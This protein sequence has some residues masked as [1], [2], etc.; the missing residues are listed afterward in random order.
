VCHSPA[1]MPGARIAPPNN[2]AR[3]ASTPSPRAS[4]TPA[5][6]PARHAD[7]LGSLRAA[8]GRVHPRVD[9][10]K[11]FLGVHRGAQCV[12]TGR[13]GAEGV[14]YLLACFVPG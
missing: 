11:I 9:T 8:I 6:A 7:L 3:E 2:P 13:H 10:V 14:R 12:T 5:L 1:N 4:K